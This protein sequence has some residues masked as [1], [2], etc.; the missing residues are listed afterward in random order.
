MLRTLATFQVLKELESRRMKKKNKSHDVWLGGRLLP[1]WVIQGRTKLN[2]IRTGVGYRI[3]FAIR[4]PSF[5]LEVN[6]MPSQ[7]LVLHKN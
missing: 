1:F 4:I 5:H 6:L 2:P 7:L 3:F